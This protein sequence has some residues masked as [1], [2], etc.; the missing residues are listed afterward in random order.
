[1]YEDYSKIEVDNIITE[2]LETYRGHLV[3]IEIDWLRMLKLV[4]VIG[5]SQR[6]V[7][8]AMYDRIKGDEQ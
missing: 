8:I 4:D 5:Q 2:L 1:M 3:E 6:D 7:L